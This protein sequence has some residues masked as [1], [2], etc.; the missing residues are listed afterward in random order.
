MSDANTPAGGAT[1]APT[2][3][4]AAETTKTP[5]VDELQ[6]SIN[7]SRRREAEAQKALKESNERLAALEA[8]DEERKK[9]EM[10]DLEK[11]QAEIAEAKKEA[12]NLSAYKLKWEEHE[13]TLKADV[14]KGLEKLTDI[15]KT[16]VE[17]IPNPDAQL[18]AIAEF[19][20]ETTKPDVSGGSG[21]RAKG[22]LTV[23][24]I[25]DMRAAG[26]AQWKTEYKKAQEAGL[27]V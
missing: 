22:V 24:E 23:K 26:N 25:I 10:S 9:A 20:Q 11:A 12:E 4:P 1:P 8:K 3:T 13:A 15:Q 16:I 5:S 27:I 6:S 7:A 2:P 21:A 18:K 14:E 17:A 19:S